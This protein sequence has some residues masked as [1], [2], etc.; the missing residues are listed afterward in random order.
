MHKKP[1]NDHFHTCCSPRCLHKLENT[2]FLQIIKQYSFY[3][4][5]TT[6][7]L[8]VQFKLLA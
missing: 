7:V 4:V 3:Q 2:P 5:L 8:H 1:P 6:Q